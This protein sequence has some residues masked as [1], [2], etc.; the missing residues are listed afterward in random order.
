MRRSFRGRRRALDV[1]VTPLIDVLFMLIIFFVLTASF[2]QG[3]IDV[4]LPSG[5]TSGGDVEGAILVTLK[6]D[7]ALK[8]GDETV[9]SGELFARAEATARQ[10]R[11]ILVAGD[12]DV[13]YGA[14]AEL[15]DSLRRAGVDRVGLALQ[16]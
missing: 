14:V 16:P 10:K 4:E 1:D 2:L 8:W 13:P 3:R 9:V 11:E 15:L 12:R 7:G 5:E 6:R